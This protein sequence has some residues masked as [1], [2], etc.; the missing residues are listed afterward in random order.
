MSGS[1]L[2]DHTADIGIAVSGKTL[3]QLYLNAARGMVRASLSSRLAHPRRARSKNIML[4][5]VDREQLLVKWLQEILFLVNAKRLVPTGFKILSLTE[6]M[7]KAQV[8]Y[9][10]FDPERHHVRREFKA[11][12]Y[13]GLF[14][15]KSGGQFRTTVIFDI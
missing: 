7:L 14:I 4:K 6:R 1:R 8:S 9:V 13:H 11:A 3:K 12:T 2:V 15:K 10:P 5:A